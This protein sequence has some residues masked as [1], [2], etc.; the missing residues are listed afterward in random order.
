MGTDTKPMDMAMHMDTDMLMHT[1]MHTVMDTDMDMH[2]DM[3]M[4]TDMHSGRRNTMTMRSGCP[5]RYTSPM[6]EGG[7]LHP[8]L[9]NATRIARMIYTVVWN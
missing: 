3:E 8:S 9:A 6:W 2:T 5:L 7:V 4:G 1:V